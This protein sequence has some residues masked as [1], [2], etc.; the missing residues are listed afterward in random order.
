MIHSSL[1]SKWILILDGDEIWPDN[2][3]RTIKSFINS[4][5]SNNFTCIVV[6]TL[7]CVGD[8]FH[9]SPQSQGKY[10]FNQHTGHLNLRLI[11][12]SAFPGLAVSNPPGKFQSY[13]DK[14]KI[15]IQHVDKDKIK[16]INAPYLHM[17]H[18]RR[19]SNQTDSNAVFWRKSKY[20]FDLGEN[21]NK[22]FS[23]PSCFYLPRPSIIP[24]PWSSRNI[25]FII[26]S[27][28]QT[29]L[30]RIKNAL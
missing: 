30:R 26:N 24:S 9:I 10:R 1:K 23:Y 27:L 6:P 19:S 2:S 4:K 29:P 3:M 28:I 21:L 15:P 11:K 8:V 13:I 14:L 25:P 12:L 5:E 18:L 17:T 16:F 20:K 22:G 7:N